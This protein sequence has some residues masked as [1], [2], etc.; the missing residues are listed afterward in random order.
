MK[1]QH[2]DFKDCVVP[3]WHISDKELIDLKKGPAIPADAKLK[4]SG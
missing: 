3:T 1:L 4:F 2:G